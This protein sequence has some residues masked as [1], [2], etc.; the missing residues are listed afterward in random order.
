MRWYKLQC[1]ATVIVFVGTGKE[2]QSLHCSRKDFCF[3]N[4]WLSYPRSSG[5]ISEP[6]LSATGDAKRWHSPNP[7][8]PQCLL[9][10]CFILQA[11]PSICPIFQ[12]PRTLCWVSWATWSLRGKGINEGPIKEMQSLIPAPCISLFS[13][14]VPLIP[15][16]CRHFHW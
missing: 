5:N 12:L 9:F 3:E 11:C 6:V 2:N 1:R 13:H 14:S 16:G 15:P 8:W 10:L 7:A 4:V